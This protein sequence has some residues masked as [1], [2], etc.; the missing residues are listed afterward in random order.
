ML[1]PQSCII[2]TPN[3]NYG[4]IIRRIIIKRINISGKNFVTKKLFLFEVLKGLYCWHVNKQKDGQEH[5]KN[6]KW[7]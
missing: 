1:D 6:K 4:N 5:E 7:W 2:Q 3:I